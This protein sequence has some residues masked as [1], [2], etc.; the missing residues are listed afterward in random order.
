MQGS[1]STSCDVHS[2][3]SIFL[4]DGEFAYDDGCLKTMGF[5][6]VTELLS[7]NIITQISAVQLN[8]NSKQIS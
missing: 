7:V 4:Y 2:P 8:I 1:T 5:S 3:E 6:M